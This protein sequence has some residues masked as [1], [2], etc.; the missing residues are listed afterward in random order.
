MNI[1]SITNYTIKQPPI[2]NGG[3]ATVYL[4]ENKKFK[5]NVA[6]KILNND[7]IN[8]VNIRKRFLAEARN[9]YKMSH[10]NII[11]VIDLID[12]GDTVA[13]VM[14]YV[15]G[16][17]LKE[18]LEQNGKI[19]DE[20]I[21]TVFTQML[22]AVGYVHKQKLV[23]RDIKPSNFMIDKEGQIKLLDFGIA[24]NT[25]ISSDDYTQTGTGM[26]MGTPMYMS[27]EQVK[28]AKEINSSSDIYSLGVVLW[29][30]IM[31]KKPYDS[32][33]LSYPEIQVS[34]LK[35]PLPLT[36]TNWDLIIRKATEKLPQ[37][38]IKNTTE[39][40]R[41]ILGYQIHELEST[42]LISNTENNRKNDLGRYESTKIEPNNKPILQWIEIPAGLFMMGSPRGWDIG[43][44]GRNQDE[45]QHQ[46]NISA[47]KMSKFQIT[48]KEY[49]AFC[50][51]TGKNKPNDEG[52]G[53][54][55]RPVINVSWFDA[56]EFASW[57]GCRL[58]TE[59]EWEYACRSGTT[60]P[61][62]TGRK[63]T[64]LQANITGLNTLEVG[65]FHPNPWG[66]HDMHGNVWE[67]C[68]DFYG[69]FSK[70]IQ[71][72][73]KGPSIGSNKI[74]RGGS[75][76]NYDY[77]CRSAQRVSDLPEYFS[78]KIGFRVVSCD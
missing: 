10:S 26:Q 21:K 30:M 74:L 32:N 7:L 36:N 23:H 78:S 57:L 42:V 55:N 38:R 34:I 5:T 19:N 15:E 56:S 47:F 11:K 76:S 6:I 54:G 49:D 53:R 50:D 77:E 67:W 43:E 24:K 62:N 25:D 14:E 18:F 71:T 12:D 75:W 68:S 35:E 73:P 3:M 64:N 59:A 39:F 16:K 9:M 48:F 46:V 2:G 1:A 13:F 27:P 70:V 37:N 31:C 4:A 22:D 33:T 65:S 28:S 72:D 60:T 40:K 63:L 51:S 69:G 8:N 41:N 29:Q 61:F 66:L 17:T 45:I 58:P 52:W 20:E 44:Q